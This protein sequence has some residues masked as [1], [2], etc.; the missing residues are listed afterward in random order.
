MSLKVMTLLSVGQHPKSARDRRADQ[1]ARAIELGLTLEQAE[2]SLLHAGDENSPAL[3]MYLGMGPQ[4]LNVIQ[5]SDNADVIPALVAYLQQSRHDI[6]LTGVRAERGEASGLLPYMIAEQLGWPVLTRIVAIEMISA[7]EAEVL[8]AL[9]RGQRRALRV[10]LPFI[11]SVDSAAP[12]ARQ[13]AFGPARRSKIIR[14]DMIESQDNERLSWQQNTARKRAKRLKIVTAK[15]AAD[16]FRA[17]TAKSQSNSGKILQS[18]TTT[19]KARAILNV[20]IEE[21][22]L[23]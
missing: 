1:D 3:R 18:E 19:E 8:Q 22:V 5:Q 21:G 14:V 15:T 16:R 13:S 7:D 17:A 10:K 6:V 12:A 20:L 4:Q 2:L 11:A 9:P 23:K